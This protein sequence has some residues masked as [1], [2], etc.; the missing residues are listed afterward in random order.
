MGPRTREP[1]P[2]SARAR[3]SLAERKLGRLQ[4]VPL[5]LRGKTAGPLRLLQTGCGNRPPGISPF[6]VCGK[7]STYRSAA[8]HSGITVADRLIYVALPA[9]L[10]LR[11]KFHLV[12]TERLAGL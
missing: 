11:T 5:L 2:S 8:R 3:N 9:H 1:G 10:S 4:G 6:D 7:Q 12:I